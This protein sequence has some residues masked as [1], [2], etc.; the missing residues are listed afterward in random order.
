MQ[1]KNKKLKTGFSLVEITVVLLI[2]GLII[3]AISSG[4]RIF[5][6]VK[7]SAARSISKGSV[8]PSIGDV[9]LWLDATSDTSFLPDEERDLSKI[10]KW[11]GVSPFVNY[12]NFNQDTEANKPEYRR[13]LINGLPAIYG[14]ASAEM[15]YSDYKSLT[16]NATMFFVINN[17][18]TRGDRTLFTTTDAS[19]NSKVNFSF[20][21]DNTSSTGDGL[22]LCIND[23]ICKNSA[24]NTDPVPL[25]NSII[26]V[27]FEEKSSDAGA[28]SFF[29]NGRAHGLNT[30]TTTNDEFQFV[31]KGN[32]KLKFNEI[33]I[34]EVIIFSKVLNEDRRKAV[35]AYLAKKWDIIIY[36]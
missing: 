4:S 21:V 12:I 18:A 7:L 8:V 3:A 9:T 31:E 29:L 20:A 30:G 27:I 1:N 23:T 19:D 28:I 15:T 10:S 25:A 17:P 34:G 35:E 5:A 22:E 16:N 33:A 14:T 13:K 2:V 24:V 36:H 6:N 32:L 11:Y 26:S